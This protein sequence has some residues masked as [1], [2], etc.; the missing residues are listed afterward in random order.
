MNQTLKGW[1][2]LEQEGRT[3]PR[4]A[5]ISPFGAGGANAHLIV[6]EYLDDKEEA[7]SNDKPVMIVL[8]ARTTEQL[9]CIV[10]NLS[11][12][13]LKHPDVN[14]TDLAYT[15]QVGR[16]AM[17]ER[18]GMVISSCEQLQEKLKAYLSEK[19]EMI[20]VYSG[21][22]QTNKKLLPLFKTDEDLQSTIA[23]WMKR[24]KYSNVLELWVQGV[25]IDWQ[26]NDSG[27]RT[28]RRISLPTYPFAKE[29]YWITDP[30]RRHP[31][32]ASANGA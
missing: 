8:S 2:A 22:V 7:S 31:M 24:K 16:E 1:K 28:V 17:N 9:R 10:K 20:D 27:A 29:R 32:G 19:A 5:G 23:Q 13:I 6:E 30:D 26:R 14:L 12:H 18:L 15:L 4:I 11:E 25:A 3:Q 21:Q